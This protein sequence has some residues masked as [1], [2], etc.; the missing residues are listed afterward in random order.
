[1]QE[2]IVTL[3][4]G[5]GS[6]TQLAELA[7]DYFQQDHPAKVVGH[8]VEVRLPKVNWELVPKGPLKVSLNTAGFSTAFNVQPALG[9][10]WE[11]MGRAYTHVL[12]MLA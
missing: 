7:N 8:R 9:G 6:P 4:A 10:W 2:V 12:G 3:Y 1:M 11:I 5:N